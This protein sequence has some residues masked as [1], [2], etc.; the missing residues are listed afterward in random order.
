MKIEIKEI[1]KNTIVDIPIGAVFRVE[2]CYGS[3]YYI[4]TDEHT[5]TMYGATNLRNGYACYFNYDTEVV[6]MNAKIIIED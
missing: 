2:S 4:K 3:N 6:V 1:E 5:K